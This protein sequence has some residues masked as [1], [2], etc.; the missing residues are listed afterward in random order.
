MIQLICLGA[1]GLFIAIGNMMLDQEKITFGKTILN[2]GK[3]LKETY[4]GAPERSSRK[5]A[6]RDLGP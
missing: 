1:F 4:R 3:T 5:T 6:L 2:L